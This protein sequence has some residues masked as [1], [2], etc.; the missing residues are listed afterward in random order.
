[1]S[2][3]AVPGT[4]VGR[5]RTLAIAALLVGAS[6]VPLGSVTADSG[7]TLRFG[8]PI[9][10]GAPAGDD[11]EPAIAAASDGRISVLFKHYDVAAGPLA[12]CGD[13]SGCDQRILVQG[14]LDGGASFG[15]PTAI[16][17]GRT[18]YDSQL[19][20]DPLDPNRVYGSF[21]VETKSSIG[22]VRSLDGGATWSATRV[23]DPLTK[24]TDKDVLAARGDDAYIAYNAFQKI[25]ISASHD[26]GDTWSTTLGARTAQ[27]V[28]GWSLP[29]AGVVTPSGE[30]LFAWSG[31]ERNGG[32]KGP[33]NLYVTRSTDGGA[34]WQ[35]V[36]VDRSE[37]APPCGCSAYAFYGAQTALA[38]D[39]SGRI[40]ALYSLSAT[41]YRPGR[42]L[43]RTSDDG[44]VTWGAPTDVSGAPDGANG[45]FPALAAAG[46][47]VRIAWM[48]DRTGAYRVYLRASDD[49]G[50]TFGP[51][52]VLSTDLD[53]PYQSA[54][55]FTFPYGD[56]FELD[57]TPDGRTV[58]VWGEGPGYDGPGNVFFAREL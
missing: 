48:D 37:T 33:V 13:P 41:P 18:G 43:H 22:F 8:A 4:R 5:R 20:T 11:W 39:G 53:Y 24:A 1:M 31:Q 46:S 25:Y 35:T 14:S 58:A 26:G 34:T 27:G 55:G 36:L 50:S 38:V 12:A 28:L 19:V 52:T 42:I 49:G 9:R 56:Y 15:A 44:G 51:E 17:P 2:N 54:D 16:D 47:E 30:V 40:H 23:V 6:V 21:L 7:P 29:S 32:A 10:L 3:L 45:A 57:I